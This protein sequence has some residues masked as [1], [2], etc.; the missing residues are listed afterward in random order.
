MLFDKSQN[1]VLAIRPGGEGRRHRVARRLAS[2]RSSC[3]SVAS[4]LFYEGRVF[5][6]KDGGILTCLDAK[7]GKAHKSGPRDGH[8]QLLRLA[9]RPATARSICSASAGRSRS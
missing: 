6:V 8:R 4:P 9:R 5:T 3:R 1:A 7:T 2:S